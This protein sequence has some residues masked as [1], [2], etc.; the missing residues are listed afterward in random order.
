MKILFLIV[1]AL[2]APA[3][4]ASECHGRNSAQGVFSNPEEA[5]SD[6]ALV[7][8]ACLNRDFGYGIFPQPCNCPSGYTIYSNSDC[9]GQ[10]SYSAGGGWTTG[11]QNWPVRSYR[12]EAASVAIRCVNRN[13]GHGTFSRPCE[14]LSGYRVFGNSGCNGQTYHL[15]RDSGWTS[16]DQYMVV[17]SYQCDAPDPN[18][19]G[20]FNHNYGRGTFNKPSNCPF[21]YTIYSQSGCG[22][23]S[24]HFNEGGWTTGPNNWLVQSYRCDVAKVTSTE[25]T[26]R[27]YGIGTFPKPAECAGSYT[28]FGSAGCTG[29]MVQRGASGW[30]TRQGDWPVRSFR[31][32]D[33]CKCTR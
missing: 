4:T 28:I 24:V 8:S 7:A 31:C 16:N 26:N 29:Q 27:Q 2:C 10:S 15:S 11:S 6:A 12:C 22:A 13:F 32:N 5:P 33:D 14:C 23:Q 3:L 1:A 19:G 20:C 25:C 18:L 17:K 30:T 9:G 21:G